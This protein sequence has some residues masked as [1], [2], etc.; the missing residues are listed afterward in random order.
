MKKIICYAAVC[1]VFLLIPAGLFAY[2]EKTLTLGGVVGWDAAENRE[3]IVEIGTVRPN[4]VLALSSARDI[5]SRL[6][7]A[8]GFDESRPDLFA[9]NA[10]NYRVS[11][12]PAVSQA[13]MR[14]ARAGFGA[15]RFSGVPV[16]SS[17]AGRGDDEP[18]VI[19]P[20]SRE[21]LLSPEPGFRDFTLEFWLYPMNLENGEEILA[22]TATRLTGRG[23]H[24]YQRIQCAAVRNRLQWSFLDFFS[25]PGEGGRLTVSSRGV[26]PIAPR[27]WSHHLIRFDADT[28]LLE[29]LVNGIPE[30]A[31][32]VT[33]T[34]HE[35]GEV[36]V[37][38]I[39][40]GGRMVLGGRFSGL[41]DEFRLYGSFVEHPLLQKYPSR[42]GRVETRVLDLGE[43]NSRIVRVD[44][45]GGRTS[46]AGLIGDSGTPAIL[47]EPVNEY[48]GSGSFN[49]ADDSAIRFFIRTV[50][51]PYPNTAAGWRSFEPGTDLDGGLS[52]FGGLSV[53]GGLG[54][55]RGRFI[56]LAAEFYPSG[57]GETTPYLEELRITYAA[58]EPPHPPPMITAIAR[59][60]AVDLS[61]R[62]S[63][64]RDVQGY[65]VYYGTSR[66]DYFGD[67]AVLGSSPVNA[68]TRT[69]IH[70]D[71]LK[72]GVLYYFAVS[73]YDRPN[74][75]HGGEFSREVSARPLKAA[76]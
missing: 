74:A 34:G 49:F 15:A 42:E 28:G 24:L 52:T 60:G 31:L 61:W 58:D 19:V 14:R 59:D 62:P 71:G 51:S 45:F 50:D 22:W 32:Y 54:E 76:D 37:P 1:A 53:S 20:R 40:E 41:M 18:L 67:G 39:G 3:G 2:G 55:F 8:I 11:V 65:L 17:L 35:G 43:G 46:N 64:D 44:A 36:Y 29:Y 70:L 69:S 5:D 63:P 26:S 6:D 7:M 4:P 21:A 47:I 13:G 10:G 66:A 12:S 48:G 33:S 27:T 68:G 9:D 38:V 73:A 16:A 23:E 56:Q 25:P 57:N 30:D 75:V 72:N